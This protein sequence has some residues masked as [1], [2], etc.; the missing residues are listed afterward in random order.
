MEPVDHEPWMAAIGRIAVR[1]A[2]LGELIDNI[3]SG[4]RPGERGK[5]RNGRMIGRKL[6]EAMEAS[7]EGLLNGNPE[8][9]SA[10]VTFCNHC[11]SLLPDRNG[12]VH[13]TYLL[14]EDED[15]KITGIIQWDSR[16]EPQYVT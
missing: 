13:S 4:V 15:E 2:E 3:T 6:S 1:A 5:D 16:R 9:A 10:F 7:G 8:L 12:A 14:D 11:L